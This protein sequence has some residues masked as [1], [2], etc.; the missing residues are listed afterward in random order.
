MGQR[1]VISVDV[2]GETIAKLYYHWSA[3]TESALYETQKVVDCI[4]NHEDESVK[5]LQLRLIRFC[6]AN[7]GGIDGNADEFKYIQNMFPNEKF[8]EDGYSRTRGL[9]ALSEKGMDDMQG[10]SEGDVIIDL[11]EDLINFGVY[12]GGYSLEEY[13]ENRKEWDDEFEG[14]T[15]E[16][17][18]NIEYDLGWINVEDLDD[19]AAA[20][21]EAR[22]DV[23]RYDNEIY[24]LIC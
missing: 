4:Y 3:Y 11:D 23:V 6:E 10:W 7:G 13:I 20:I 17:I 8:I 16:E 14:I 18:P 9:I 15:L 12:A 24:E 5:E 1:L 2:M 22:S 19:V 21:E